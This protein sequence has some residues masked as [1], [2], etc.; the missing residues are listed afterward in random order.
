MKKARTCHKWVSRGCGGAPASL[1][2]LSR[3]SG[4]AQ[5]SYVDI[6]VKDSGWMVLTSNGWVMKNSE[7]CQ[8]KRWRQQVLGEMGRWSQWDLLVKTGSRVTPSPLPGGSPW[9][10]HFLLSQP[11][12]IWFLSKFVSNFTNSPLQGGPRA[13][14]LC[15]FLYIKKTAFLVGCFE[16]AGWFLVIVVLWIF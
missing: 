11:M 10:T 8:P 14:F 2:S 7:R 9:G 3:G 13:E 15:F 16:L 4:S 1:W 12:L 6:H 5:D